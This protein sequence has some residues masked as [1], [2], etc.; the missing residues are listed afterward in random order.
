MI[1]TRL[2]E[3]EK[4]KV[5]VYIDD[6]YAFLLY[7]NDIRK[8]HLEEQIEITPEEYHEILESTIFRRAKQKALAVLKFMNRTEKGLRNKLQE[9]GYPNDIVD[10]TISYVCEYGYVNDERYARAYIRD[11]K[12]SKS[13]RILQNELLH[14]GIEKDILDTLFITEYEEE[15]AEDP[16]LIAIKKAIA[17]KSRLPENLN[18]EEKQKLIASLYRKGFELDK[19]KQCL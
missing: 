15:G 10:R 17:K 2:E 7:N 1:I 3:L 16:E 6:E 14:K 9:A 19:I 18:W 11:R 13:K 5:K 4:S 8:F 12:K